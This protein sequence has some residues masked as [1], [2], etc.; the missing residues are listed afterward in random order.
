MSGIPGRYAFGKVSGER[1]K[2]SVC[3]SSCTFSCSSISISECFSDFR[4]LPLNCNQCKKLRANSV[5]SFA[6]FMHFSQL[7]P[8]KGKPADCS[9]DGFTRGSAPEQSTSLGRTDRPVCLSVRCVRENAGRFSFAY[10]SFPQ[11]EKYGYLHFASSFSH[12]SSTY[13]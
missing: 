12:W 5:R 13:F 8:S 4:R 3:C 2:C 9:S 6:V 11:K 1:W 7:K 10:F